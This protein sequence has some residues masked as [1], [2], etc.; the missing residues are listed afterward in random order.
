MTDLK[1]PENVKRDVNLKSASKTIRKLALLVA[2]PCTELLLDNLTWDS[3]KTSNFTSIRTMLQEIAYHDFVKI[4]FIPRF[5]E[6]IPEN[7]HTCN[8]KLVLLLSVLNSV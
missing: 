5:D 1:V 6:M 4:R 2:R 7:D 8:F 3:G